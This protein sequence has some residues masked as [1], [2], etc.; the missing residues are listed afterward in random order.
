MQA[1]AMIQQ[2]EEKAAEKREMEEFKARYKALAKK[3]R[4]Q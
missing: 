2:A 1:A 3:F 4:G